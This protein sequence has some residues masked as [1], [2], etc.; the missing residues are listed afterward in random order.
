MPTN[1]TIKNSNQIHQLKVTQEDHQVDP[2]VKNLK[3]W[4]GTADKF[5]KPG[6]QTDIWVSEGRRVIIQEL[7]T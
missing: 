7:P 2:K 3:L 5:L 4:K 1:I 6:E